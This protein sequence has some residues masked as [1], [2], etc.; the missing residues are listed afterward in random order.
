M[1]PRVH[2]CMSVRPSVV[3]LFPARKCTGPQPASLS[4]TH[5][6]VTALRLTQA[7]PGPACVCP[8]QREHTGRHITSRGWTL[9]GMKDKHGLSPVP[10][11]RQLWS[12]PYCLVP[13]HREVGAAGKVLG[14]GNGGVEVEHNVPPAS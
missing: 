1:A 2:A 13:H 10:L 5:P 12:P 3:C 9:E 11:P 14:D 6:M 7:W 4:L 8:Q